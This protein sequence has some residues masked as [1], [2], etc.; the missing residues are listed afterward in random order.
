MIADLDKTPQ[1]V[2]AVDRLFAVRRALNEF[3][4]GD[5]RAKDIV[6]SL[7]LAMAEFTPVKSDEGVTGYLT[8]CFPDD[9]DGVS[10]AIDGLMREG[11]TGRYHGG[12][13]AFAEYTLE[14]VRA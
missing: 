13:G 11:T 6:Q 4:G 8:A 5:P 2:K 9:P 10:E 14:R 12:G 1:R 7:D 3:F